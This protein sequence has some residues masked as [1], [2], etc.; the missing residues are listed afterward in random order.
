[1]VEQRFR[2][3][4]GA[5]QAGKPILLPLLERSA[6]PRVVTPARRLPTCAIGAALRRVWR[7]G[8]N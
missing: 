2:S 5:L 7:G 4:E 3:P 8:E 1:M 6:L